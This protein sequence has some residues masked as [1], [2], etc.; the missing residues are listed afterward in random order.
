[1]L[2]SGLMLF[3]KSP[4]SYTG[5]DMLEFHLHGG[6]AVKQR[7][8]ETLSQFE[9]FREAEPVSLKAFLPKT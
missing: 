7:F 2:D 5:E 9:N 3:F 6:T 4:S 1:M 8:L